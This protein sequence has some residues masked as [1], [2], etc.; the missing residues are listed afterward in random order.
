MK[1]LTIVVLLTVLLLSTAA[2]NPGT[3]HE[4]AAALSA[5]AEAYYVGDCAWDVLCALPGTASEDPAEVL[6]SP[7]CAALHALMNETRSFLPAYSAAKGHF[8]DTDACGGSSE[9]LRFYCDDFGDYGREQVWPD[10]LGNFYHEGAGCDLHHLRPA[11][12]EINLA[13][14]SLGFGNVRERFPD[15]ASA[16]AGSDAPALWYVEG[17]GESGLAEPRD[18]VKG[19]VARI[20]LYVFVTWGDPAGENLNLWTDRPVSGA[21]ISTNM[22]RRVIE[23]LDTL[24]EWMALDPVDTWELGRNDVVERIEGSRNVFIDYPEL[25]FLLFDREIPDMPTPSGRAHEAYCTLSAVPQP[26]A[27]GTV[28]VAG[29]S[30]LAQPAPGW[31]LTGWRLEPADAADVSLEGNTFTLTRL[32]ESCTLYVQFTQTDPCAAGHDWDEGTV[33]REPTQAQPGEILYHCLRCGA[34]QTEALPFRFDDVQNENAYFFTP[35]YWALGCD[36]PITTGTDETHFSP[37]KAC[38]RAQVV[39][40]LWRAAGC[41]APEPGAIPFIDV[42]ESAYYADAVRWAAGEGITNGT[43]SV[44][45]S[46]HAACTRA[47]IVSFLWKAAGSPDPG[48]AEMPFADVLPGAYYYRAVLWAAQQGI[49]L[50]VTE[51]SFA[52]KLNCTRAQVVTFL[53][54]AFGQQRNRI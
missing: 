53:W 12:S 16:P 18:N 47:Q 13:H 22:G 4:T 27:G 49:V 31:A 48:P 17:P 2:S 6:Q 40:F 39:T 32:R 44:S 5:Q 8:S 46:P 36:P 43:S 24:L 11:N 28:S 54:R 37:G 3:R 33:L 34:E 15:C 7:L 38:T 23:D 30:V 50:G 9:P 51:D 21:G 52:P 20:L 45:F 41:P 26:Y 10:A 19:D 25:A 42:P 1:R 35:V 29:R 14:G